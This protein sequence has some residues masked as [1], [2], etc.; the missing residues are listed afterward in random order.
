NYV[1]SRPIPRYRVLAD[2]LARMKRNLDAARMQCWRAGWMADHGIPNSKEASMAKASGGRAAVEACIDA[3]D[4]VG[5]HATLEDGEHA[6]LAKWFRDIKVF[7]IFEG[8]GQIQ[9]VVISKRLY[10]GLRGF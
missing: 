6:L 7:D 3:V 9:R 1:L 10:E 4:I 2:R 5:A 8:T